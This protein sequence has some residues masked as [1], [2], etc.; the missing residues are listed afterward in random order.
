MLSLFQ[1]FRYVEQTCNLQWSPQPDILKA[2]VLIAYEYQIVVHII[3]Q[4]V[5]FSALVQHW[6]H[7]DVDKVLKQAYLNA[8]LKGSLKRLRL[9]TILMA[10]KKQGG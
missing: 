6:L 1:S 7:V 3:V 5:D 9:Y 10:L 2:E 8:V 4:T